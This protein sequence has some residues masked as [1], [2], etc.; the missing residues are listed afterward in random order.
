MCYEDYKSSC[1]FCSISASNR[2][3]G[4]LLR[5]VEREVSR[6]GRLRN[7]ESPSGCYQRSSF[8]MLPPFSASF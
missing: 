1:R 5:L 4:F 7:V 2:K 6:P 8:G 3:V